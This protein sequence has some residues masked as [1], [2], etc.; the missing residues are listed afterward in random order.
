M[1]R[2]LVDNYLFLARYNHWFKIYP[3]RGTIAQ[4]SCEAVIR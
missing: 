2:D 3:G 1:A 4:K